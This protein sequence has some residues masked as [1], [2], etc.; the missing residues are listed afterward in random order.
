MNLKEPDKQFL[1]NL[2]TVSKL[3][4]EQ[5]KEALT[6]ENGFITEINLSTPFRKIKKMPSFDG[7]TKL[8]TLRLSEDTYA[9]AKKWLLRKLVVQSTSLENIEI[10]VNRLSEFTLIAPN[11]LSLKLHS[12][13]LTYLEVEMMDKLTSLSLYSYGQPFKKWEHYASLIEFLKIGLPSDRVRDDDIF[14]SEELPEISNYSSLTDL[15]IDG[16]EVN[17][18]LNVDLENHKDL[19]KLSLFA[20]KSVSVIGNPSSLWKYSISEYTADT[21][22]LHSFAN[23]YNWD[24]GLYPLERLIK[25]KQCSKDTAKMI[26]WLAK[27]TWFLQY[28]SDEAVPEIHKETLKLIRFIERQFEAG[29]IF[30]KMPFKWK[31]VADHYPELP[32]KRSIPEIMYSD[33]LE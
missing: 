5:V 23:S 3:D 11:T 6:I 29:R 4:D 30:V 21:T 31:E 13:K 20:G 16:R 10:W 1:E 8:K 27:P 9:K 24:N 32:K 25:S 33:N 26:Y 15:F 12:G 2:T 19:K 17:V 7:L 14:T 28:E 22:T 18:A